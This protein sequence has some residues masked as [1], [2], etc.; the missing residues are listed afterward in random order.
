MSLIRNAITKLVLPAFEKDLSSA[1]QREINV[2]AKL[3]EPAKL[4]TAAFRR[5]SSAA[6]QQILPKSPRRLITDEPHLP[7]RLGLGLVVNRVPTYCPSS[8]R[9][10]T[11]KF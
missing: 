6:G 2:M 3:C 8:S 5:R 7:G 9:W 1:L 10:A 4:I 11:T